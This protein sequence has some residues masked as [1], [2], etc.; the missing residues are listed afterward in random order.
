M[1]KLIQPVIDFIYLFNNSNKL[2]KR[3]KSRAIWV[4]VLLSLM[5]AAII[6]FY[7]TKYYPLISFSFFFGVLSTFVTGIYEAYTLDTIKKVVKIVSLILFLTGLAGCIHSIYYNDVL[8][9]YNFI[10][11]VAFFIFDYR[12]DYWKKNF[13]L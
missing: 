2:S 12:L 6:G 11:F 13:T 3:E 9:I 1:N 7:I 10:Y 8:N 4:V 5:I